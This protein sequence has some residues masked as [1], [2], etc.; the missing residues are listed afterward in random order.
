MKPENACA[1]LGTSTLVYVI[2]EGFTNAIVIGTRIGACDGPPTVVLAMIGTLTGA[3]IGAAT[4]CVSCNLLV[5]DGGTRALLIIACIFA[6]PFPPLLV[7][8]LGVPD[9]ASLEA[10][11]GADLEEVCLE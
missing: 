5:T 10:L 6:L 1:L 11:G 4:Q 2:L 8:F 9:G 7:F 3:A